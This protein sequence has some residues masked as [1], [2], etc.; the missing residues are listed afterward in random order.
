MQSWSRGGGSRSASSR[1][2][3][4]SSTWR[5]AASR[6]LNPSGQGGQSWS[7]SRQRLR[8]GDEMTSATRARSLLRFCVLATLSVL[9]LFPAGAAR[10][11]PSGT[12]LAWG[13][14]GFAAAGQCKVPS[15]LSG[16]TA[17]SAGTFHSLA[18]KSDGTVVAWG[19]AVDNFGQC[20]VPSGLSGV[21]AIAAG[22]FQSLALKSDGTV[23]AWGCGIDNGQ[24]D[25]PSGLSGV[26]AVAAGNVHRLAL[27]SDGTVVAWGCGAGSDT[28]Q[29]DVPSGLSGVTAIAAGGGHSLALKSDGT[30]VA[31]GCA[32]FDWGQCDV[33]SGLSGVVAIAAGDISSLALKSNGTVVGWGCGLGDAGQ[34]SVPAGLSGV[35]A[36]SAGHTHSLALRS[37]GTVVAWG[38][39]AG[40]NPGQCAVPSGLSSVAALAA[41]VGQSLALVAPIPAV[42]GFSPAAGGV[43]TLV[44][45]NG[46]NVGSATSVTF[47][48]VTATPT[49]VSPT[50]IRA[51]VPAGARTGKI[52]VTNPNGTGLSAAVFKVLPKLT[53]FSPGSGAA[54][55]SVTITGSGFT[56]V[57]AV[58]F[59]GVAATSPSID[60]DH[61]ITAT[62]PDTA[63]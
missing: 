11:T 57:S 4:C 58:K 28:G 55:A 9:L 2:P 21:T 54:G 30:V 17:V 34:C 62:V 13:C 53:S 35:T 27:K 10:A 40:N 43:G 24:C 29:C 44:T 41:G 61:Q 19:C 60:S 12:V 32:G 31:W 14:G 25:V 52:G 26:T 15:G 1:A 8:K 22:S 20:N 33:P 42:S 5:T 50:Q 7:A 59:N 47:G 51:T 49:I 45:I 63:T 23:V 6:R 18:L 46:R 39:G 56:D 36:I 48:G 3:T 37:N 38:C 16:V